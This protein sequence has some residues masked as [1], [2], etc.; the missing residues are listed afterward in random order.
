MVC[1]V[2]LATLMSSAPWRGSS[3]QEHP[4]STIHLPQIAFVTLD[5][6]DFNP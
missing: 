3:A 4:R 1:N 5:T 6:S 2:S